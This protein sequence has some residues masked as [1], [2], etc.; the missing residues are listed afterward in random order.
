MAAEDKATSVAEAATSSAAAT[1][2]APAAA[3]TSAAASNGATGGNNNA[4]AGGAIAGIAAPA[5]EDSGDKTRPF[6]VN[7]NTFVNKGA[8]VQRACAIQNN[9]CADAVNSG[10]A[11]GS[12]VGDCNAQEQT[13]N[14]N[15][16]A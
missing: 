6:L 8:A 1:E 16:G 9:A 5:V 15:G 14:A 11:A 4:A 12:T 13:C 7:G 2:S 3:T 10:K